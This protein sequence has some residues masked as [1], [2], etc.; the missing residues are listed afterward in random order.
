MVGLFCALLRLYRNRKLPTLSCQLVSRGGSADIA[1]VQDIPMHNYGHQSGNRRERSV[2]V[3]LANLNTS[4][5]LRVDHV[6]NYYRITRLS[7]IY[8]RSPEAQIT[9]YYH[10]PVLWQN[11]FFVLG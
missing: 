8:M 7:T 11:G 6:F 1:G 3:H 10:N 9:N 5:F 4:P 2:H